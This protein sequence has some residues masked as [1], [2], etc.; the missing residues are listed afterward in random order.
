[1]RALRQLRRS[2][3]SRIATTVERRLRRRRSILRELP[4]QI[5]DPDA[6]ERVV[7]EVSVKYP[8]LTVS[9][10]ND[11]VVIAG[12]FR[13]V[14]D[15]AELFSYDIVIELPPNFPEGVPTVCEVG[16]RIPRDAD[17]QVNSDGTA[18]LFVAGERWRHWPR[19]SSLGDF[20]SGPVRSYLIGQA[21]VEAGQPWPF[22]ER[23]HGAKGVLEAYG[24]MA[25]FADPKVVT[26][27]ICSLARPKLRRHRQCPCGTGQLIRDCHLALLSDLREK[28]SRVEAET[29]RR[30]IEF[31]FPSLFP[32]AS[33]QHTQAVRRLK[34]A[35]YSLRPWRT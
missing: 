15:S 32:A 19:G 34:P 5:A 11:R 8:E 24:E 6:Y 12:L 29:A 16:G 14:G 18:C 22:G 1:M 27:F 21:L 26:S 3:R 28:I 7:A 9:S 23:A 33:R 17:H 2:V 20:I 25:G 13:E 30:Q 35:Q 10:I 31:E 4:W